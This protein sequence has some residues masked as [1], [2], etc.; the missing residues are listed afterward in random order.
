MAA[1][2]IASGVDPKKSNIFVQSAV[3]YEGFNLF[4]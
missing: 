2:L 3:I 1:A 4:E